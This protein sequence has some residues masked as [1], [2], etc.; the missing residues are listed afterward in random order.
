MINISGLHV[1][2]SVALNKSQVNIIGVAKQYK[3]VHTC[4]MTTLNTTDR[5]T[6]E[7]IHIKNRTDVHE[8]V[9]I[10]TR[11]APTR[12]SNTAIAC[13]IVR[14][15]RTRIHIYLYK[16]ILDDTYM[17]ILLYRKRTIARSLYLAGPTKLERGKEH[18]SPQHLQKLTAVVFTNQNFSNGL[19]VFYTRTL[20]T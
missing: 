2:C 13:Y 10:I 7:D 8:P 12:R 5:Y 20:S 1:I 4:K 11:R 14:F 17:V 19:K 15:T 9:T 3:K 6:D 18:I 16:L